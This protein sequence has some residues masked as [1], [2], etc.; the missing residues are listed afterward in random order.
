MSKKVEA[1]PVLGVCSCL[2]GRPEL[3]MPTEHELA[4]AFGEVALK[5]PPFRF[6]SSDYYREELGAELQRTWYCFST[7]WRAERL[8]RY[9]LR[10]GRIEEQLAEAGKRRVNLDPGY[11]DQ[12]K[13]VL[14]SLKEAP[15]KIYMGDGVWAHTCL[16]YGEGN[17]TAPDHSFPDFRDGRFNGFMSEARA[18]YK[19]LLREPCQTTD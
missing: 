14:A 8:P 4:R 6:D 3:L 13:L 5:S 7:L 2:F 1:S 11:L 16:R 12:G 19:S 15:D 10:T 17:F 9:R 18:L